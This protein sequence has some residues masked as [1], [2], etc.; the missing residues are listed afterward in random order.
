MSEGVHGV[1]GSPES[2]VR[3]VLV[4]VDRAAASAIATAL[5]NAFCPLQHGGLHPVTSQAAEC[6]CVSE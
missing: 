1:R 2:E 6:E 4:F 5:I 3:S